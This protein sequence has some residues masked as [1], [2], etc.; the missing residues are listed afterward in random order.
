MAEALRVAICLATF[1][2]DEQALRRQISSLREQTLRDW[3]CWVVDDGSGLASLSII[4]RVLDGDPRFTLVSHQQNVG[5]YRNFERGLAAVRGQA[6]HVALAD[7]D[8]IWSPDKLSVLLDAL[9]DC[10]GSRLAYCDMEIRLASGTAVSPTYWVGRRPNS[11]DLPALLFANTVSGAACMFVDD[12]LSIT[13]PFPPEHPSS[14]HDHWLALAAR[15][16]GGIV[17]VDRPLQVYVQH[18]ENAIGHRPGG[19][20]SAARAAA[21]LFTRPFWR[22]PAPRYY[23]DEVRRLSELAAQLL[24]RAGA[25]LAPEDARVLLAASRLHGR[26]P[27]L[28]W[29]LLQCLAEAREPS[30]TMQRRRRVLAS[31]LWTQLERVGGRSTP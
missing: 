29:L 30:V 12:L 20:G 3:H 14:F 18:G 1:R 2:P 22:R 31:V 7:Q 4:R 11:D 15:I 28:L 8:D 17:Y 27:P 13:L 26:R 24:E 6:A 23:D 25:R 10:P 21:R 19:G 5:F 16:S 9:V